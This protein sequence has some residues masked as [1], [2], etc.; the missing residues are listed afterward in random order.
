[1][2]I[3]ILGS[4][5]QIGK[6]LAHYTRQKGHS[7][8]EYDIRKSIYE[9]L[10]MFEPD[11]KIKWE[12]LEDC[13][14]GCDFVFFL[15]WDVGG[16]KYL[17]DAESSFSFIHNNVAI[18]NSTFHMLKKHN[19]P[20]VFT[21]SQMAGMTHSP[22]GNT[23]VIGERYTKA[24]G[25]ISI[26]LWNVYGYEEVTKRSH[27]ITDFVEMGLSGD[28]IEM[29]TDGT[30]T[31][32]F[33]YVEDCCEALFAMVELYDKISRDE[34]LH[35]SSYSWTSIE[36]VAKVVSTLCNCSYIKGDLKD[37]VQMSMQEEPNKNALKYWKPKTSICEGIKCIIKKMKGFQN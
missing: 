3:L 32:Q 11:R 23:K 16:S 6:P 18:M 27:V 33:L 20:F 8:I 4:E 24:L 31:R 17:S 9:D 7:V 34:E 10:R 12:Y 13:V 37:D 36:E 30:E 1:M 35:V 15:A 5:G 25:G 19:K 22:Y 14:R 26:R 2:K 29:R 28:V 21:S